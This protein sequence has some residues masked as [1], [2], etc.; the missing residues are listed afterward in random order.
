MKMRYSPLETIALYSIWYYN[1]SVNHDFM[2]FYEFCNCYDGY[3]T[4]GEVDIVCIVHEIVE[5][6]GGT[7][8]D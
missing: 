4:I 6:M 3:K 1:K 8:K 5:D 2:N 7:S